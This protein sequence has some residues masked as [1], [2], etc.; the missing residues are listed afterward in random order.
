MRVIPKCDKGIFSWS[1]FDP[2]KRAAEQDLYLAARI[3]R[4][5]EAAAK[6]GSPVDV[7]EALVERHVRVTQIYWAA[8]SRC[9]SSAVAGPA[10][11]PVARNQKALDRARK[12]D[13]EVGL[14]V[15]AAIKRLERLAYPHGLPGDPI[16]ANDPE[17]VAK[18]EAKL[19]G[20]QECHEMALAGNKA[21]RAHGDEAGPFLKELG[22]DDNDVKHA[23]SKN[24][25]GYHWGF[26]VANS[27]ANIARTAERLEQ[28]K[29]SLAKE[30]KVVEIDGV[31]IVE[32]VE[33]QRVQLK[34]PGKPAPEVI[35]LLKGRGFRWAPSVGAWQRNLNNAGI[36]AAKEIVKCLN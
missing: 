36:Y 14:H 19:K 2:E 20:L 33:M 29:K 22:F 27:R 28:L 26:F 9:A 13:N 10:R 34:F 1:S 6:F 12:V 35:K 3:Q 11:F 8:Q 15:S 4:I 17:A 21:I 18:L 23:L 32:N 30:T 25:G 24:Y 16:R 5:D 31:V 7:V